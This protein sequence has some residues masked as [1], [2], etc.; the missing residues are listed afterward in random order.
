VKLLS[1]LDHLIPDSRRDHA[2]VIS[3]LH[4][5]TILTFNAALERNDFSLAGFQK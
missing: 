3:Q 5:D 2:T 4:P 1:W